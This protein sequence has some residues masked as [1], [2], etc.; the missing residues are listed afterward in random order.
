MMGPER[1]K[2]KTAPNP[3]EHRVDGTTV[4]TLDHKGQ[5][6]ECVIDTADFPL[7]SMHTWSPAKNAKTFYAVRTLRIDGKPT[8]IYMHS[9]IFGSQNPDHKDRNGLNNRRSNLR[10]ATR[11]QQ[12]VNQGI[13][14]GRQ[15]KGV[16]WNTEN[17][18][19][20]AMIRVNG[21]NTYL[22]LFDTQEAAAKA[23]DAAA[24]QHHGE[25]AVLNFPQEGA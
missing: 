2:Q 10:P 8:R 6:L 15:F 19:W 7:V 23:Y 18:C 4:I 25:F 16:A 3:V 1:G 21:K 20:R 14:E 24:K 13:K 5:P 17:N 11:H 22:G 12:Q 9:L